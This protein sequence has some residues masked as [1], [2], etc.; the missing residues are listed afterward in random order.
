MIIGREGCR[1]AIYDRKMKKLEG[2]LFRTVKNYFAIVKNPLLDC[3]RRD[4]V[5]SWLKAPMFSQKNF[6]IKNL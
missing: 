4:L 1:Y 5:A 3:N 2:M 6:L